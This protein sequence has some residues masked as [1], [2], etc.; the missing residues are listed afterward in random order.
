MIRL[1]HCKVLIHYRFYHDFFIMSMKHTHDFLFFCVF[2]Q[3]TNTNKKPPRYPKYFRF[4]A[5]DEH[6]FIPPRVSLSHDLRFLFSISRS[7]L[8]F[9]NI[10]RLSYCKL[11]NLVHPSYHFALSRNQ[12]L[13]FFISVHKIFQSYSFPSHNIGNFPYFSP[14]FSFRKSLPH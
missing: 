7:I 11:A 13:I 14:V 12:N 4:E 2:G 3:F 5:A 9:A 6:Y 10:L 8:D 1:K